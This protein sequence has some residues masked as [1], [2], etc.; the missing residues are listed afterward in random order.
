MAKFKISDE[1]KIPFDCASENEQNP[2]KMK[3][4][5]GW[6]T[7]LEKLTHRSSWKARW[8]GSEY[9]WMV[10]LRLLPEESTSRQSYE[11]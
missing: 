11:R 9:V 1:V 2:S 5:G 6:I 10:Q 7:F 3:L 4:K 8:Q